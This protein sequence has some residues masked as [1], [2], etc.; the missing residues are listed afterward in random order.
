LGR[1]RHGDDGGAVEV[2]YDPHPWK[3][4][5]MTRIVH[6]HF[7]VEKLPDELRTA[8]GNATHVHLTVRDK[9]AEERLK[10]EMN[11]G[12]DRG[13]ADI[14]AGRVHS[15]EEIDAFLDKEFPVP[16]EGGNAA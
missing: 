9:D 13:L 16:A 5:A 1:K 2:W 7:P 10:A 15:A 8:F 3:V 14:A 6:P 4:A 11:A 12:I